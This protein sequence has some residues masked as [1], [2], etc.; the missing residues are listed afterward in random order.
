[1]VYVFNC[2]SALTQITNKRPFIISR[3]TFVG[4][5]K[6]SGAWTG[7]NSATWED[8]YYSIPGM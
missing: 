2:C 1:M 7:D 6:Y 4:H 8:L 3:S 5:G